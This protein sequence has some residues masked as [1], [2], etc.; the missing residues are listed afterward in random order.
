M[1]HSTKIEIRNFKSIRDFSV[2]FKKILLVI[3][4]PNTGKTNVL[5]ALTLLGKPV[6][7]FVTRCRYLLDAQPDGSFGYSFHVQLDSTYLR[8]ESDGTTFKIFSATNEHSVNEALFT[9]L[10]TD[11][12]NMPIANNPQIL[13]FEFDTVKSVQGGVHASSGSNHFVVNTPYGSNIPLIYANN[14]DFRDIANSIVSNYNIS[15]LYRAADRSL[16]IMTSKHGI[17]ATFPWSS[18]SETLRRR[19]FYSCILSTVKD[20]VI[21]LDEPDI[22]SFAPHV[23]QL[24][25]DIV[26]SRNNNRFVITAHDSVFIESIIESAAVGD[27]TLVVALHGNDGPEFT[28]LTGNQLQEVLNYAGSIPFN[29]ELIKDIV[30]H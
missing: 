17:T 22:K 4:E 7:P 28:T 6:D 23:K 30:S 15:L 10:F 25:E 18:L 24:A 2:D 11:N 5:D 14:Q 12:H 16:E 27:V 21:L 8:S 29:L 1:Q 19:V 3:G 9:G 20:S 26:K 13:R